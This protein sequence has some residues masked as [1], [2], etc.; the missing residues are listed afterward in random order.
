VFAVD[1]ARQDRRPRMGQPDLPH[2]RRVQLG[3]FAMPDLS[4]LP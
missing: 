2:E 3:A 4:R 1:T